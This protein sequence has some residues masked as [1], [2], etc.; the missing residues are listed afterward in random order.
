MR[1]TFDIPRNPPDESKILI[2]RVP[3]SKVLVSK[4]QDGSS[5]SIVWSILP[6]RLYTSTLQVPVIFFGFIRI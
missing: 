4:K 3:F 6:E 5:V 2:I 1:I